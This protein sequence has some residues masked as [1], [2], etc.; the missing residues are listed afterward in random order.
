MT[1]LFSVASQAVRNCFA[2]VTV[3]GFTVLLLLLCD[4]AFADREMPGTVMTVDPFLIISLTVMIQ[5]CL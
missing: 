1:C 2:S 5:Q 3:T 4:N